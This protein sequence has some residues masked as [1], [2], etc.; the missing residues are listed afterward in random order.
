MCIRNFALPIFL[1]SFV[2][3]PMV[4]HWYTHAGVGL[5]K[6]PRFLGRA[7]SCLFICIKRYGVLNLPSVEAS[8]V[9]IADLSE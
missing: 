4:G 1:Q 9:K 6:L 2:A 8:V 5:D 3:Q 7:V